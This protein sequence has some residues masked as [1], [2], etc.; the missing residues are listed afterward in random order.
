[1]FYERKFAKKQVLFRR[2][3][4]NLIYF[5]YILYHIWLKKSIRH[6]DKNCEKFLYNFHKNFIVLKI[7]KI[8][9]DKQREIWYNHSVERQKKGRIES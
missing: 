1:M 5:L 3:T 9:I 7:Y 4:S 8:P 2:L 6:L